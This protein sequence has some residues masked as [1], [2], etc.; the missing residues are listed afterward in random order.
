MDV[1]RDQLMLKSRIDLEI[2]IRVCQP[3]ETSKSPQVNNVEYHWTNST[4]RSPTS[5]KPAHT[6]KLDFV[7]FSALFVCA[8]EFLRCTESRVVWYELARIAKVLVE[9]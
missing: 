7:K 6:L 4:L 5:Q 9:L 2:A 8:C 1:L 3:V